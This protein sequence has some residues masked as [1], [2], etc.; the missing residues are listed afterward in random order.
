[1]AAALPEALR[2]PLMTAQWEQELLKVENGSIPADQ[3]MAD[4]REMTEKLVHFYE[5]RETVRFPADPGRQI[6]KG[7]RYRR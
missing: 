7:R 5:K 1:M 2:S 3:F 4:I 6:R